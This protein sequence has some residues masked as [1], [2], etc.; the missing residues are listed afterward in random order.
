MYHTV[1]PEQTVMNLSICAQNNLII[2]II[3][4]QI[5]LIYKS[6]KLEKHVL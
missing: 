2:K 6:S 4:T 5:I 1:Q 3:V